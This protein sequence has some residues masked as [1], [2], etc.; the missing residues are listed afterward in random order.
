MM[1]K[2][3]Y[4]LSSAE[5]APRTAPILLHGTICENLKIA[6]A[7][8]FDGIEVHTREDA[9]LDYEKIAQISEEYGVAIAVVV[10]GRLN[11]Q[12][13]V[14]LLDDRPYIVDAAMKGMREYIAIASRLNSDLVIGWIKGK[15]PA[16]ADP[17]IYLTRL[18]RNLK[19]ICREA[20]DRGVRI[21]TE[22]INRYETNI[23]TT[24]E[25]TVDF[26][27]QWDI[28]NC[29][30]HLDTFHMNIEETDPC[31]A[32]R[33]CGKKLAYFHAADNT[34]LYPGTGTLDFK[35]YYSILAEI[36]YEG[37][38]SV[39][40]LPRPDGKTAAQRALKYLKACEESIFLGKTANGG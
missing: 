2:W 18:A 21:F 10:T 26:L 20:S 6:A 27:R 22:V 9:G 5:A 35:C 32:I 19:T 37:Y 15:I 29:Y 12:G 14:N 1:S 8:G 39:E 36:G 24:A 17:Q 23:F 34:R 25:E 31:T 28:P 16:G 7:L 4:A 38:I 30:V 11:T 33:T 40:C 13:E 3:K